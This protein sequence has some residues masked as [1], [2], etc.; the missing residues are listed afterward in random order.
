MTIKLRPPP[1]NFYA[2]AAAWEAP[3]ETVV[4]ACPPSNATSQLSKGFNCPWSMRGCLHGQIGGSAD[5]S[6]TSAVTVNGLDSSDGLDSS[7]NSHIFHA[8]SP[9]QGT[10][11]VASS[12]LQ[13][14]LGVNNIGAV[15]K[16]KA[17]LNQGADPEPNFQISQTVNGMVNMTPDSHETDPIAKTASCCSGFVVKHAKRQENNSLRLHEP[18]DLESQGTNRNGGAFVRAGIVF[19]EASQSLANSDEKYCIKGKS[20]GSWSNP[21]REQPEPDLARREM[22]EI[23]ILL[24]QGLIT[25]LGLDD[26]QVYTISL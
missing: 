23:L 2:R 12:I 8:L 13:H 10:F 17:C 1:G 6:A 21:P 19:N 5:V 25:G 18:T 11:K 14:Q 24:K 4:Q 3:I 16:S 7:V 15:L 26:G 9:G 20:T 22:E